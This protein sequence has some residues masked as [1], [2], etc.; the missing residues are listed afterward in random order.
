VSEQNIYGDTGAYGLVPR[1]KTV[2]PRDNAD[3]DDFEK[4]ID[5]FIVDKS[6]APFLS[7]DSRIFT[8]GSC[9]AENLHIALTKAGYTTFYNQFKEALNQCCSL[10]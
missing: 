8:Q 7:K 3:F 1:Q 5:E 10:N 4:L 2:Y 6:I 9:F